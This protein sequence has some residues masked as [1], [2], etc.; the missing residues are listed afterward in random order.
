MLGGTTSINAMLYVRG[1]ADDFNGWNVQ[2]WKYD[3]VLPYFLKSEGN[4]K[5][6][7]G[8]Y[9]NTEGRTFLRK[10]LKFLKI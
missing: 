9:H 6:P 8:K 3:D 1:T 10:I 5:R 2:G 7:K 4:R